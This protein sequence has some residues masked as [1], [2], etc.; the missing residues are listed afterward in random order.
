MKNTIPAPTPAQL[1]WQECEL[2]M[3]YHMDPQWQRLDESARVAPEE[4]NPERFNASE[5]LDVAEGFGA[6]QI[7]MVCKHGSGFCHWQTATTDF[8]IAR[9]P[10]KNGKGDIVAELAD[11]TH[12]RGLRFGIYLAPA[13][14]HEGAG[15][16]GVCKNP[17]DQERYVALYRQQLTELLSRYGEV[18]EV[19]FDGSLVFDVSD[20]LE[21]YAPNAVVFQGKHASI[22]WLGN[23]R[24]ISP[25]PAWNG[26][27]MEDARTG[28]ATAAQST[29]DGDVWM[30]LESDT[31]IRDHKWMW[32]E[33][34]HELLKSL[35]HLIDTYYQSVGHGSVLL[36]NCNPKLDGSIDPRDKARNDEF[37]A[38]IRRRF[39]V[40]VAEAKGAGEVLEIPLPQAQMIDHV[41]SA[42]VISEGERVRAYKVEARVEGAWQVVT[43]G[44]AIGLKKIDFFEP[45]TCDAMRIV[46]TEAVEKPL[47]KRVAVYYVGKIPTFERNQA[48][49]FNPIRAGDFSLEPGERK[50][51]TI[52]LTWA[53]HIAARYDIS[54]RSDGATPIIHDAVFR[55][56][57]T[58]ARDFLQGLS[59]PGTWQL[60][61]TA[62]EATKELELTV[63]NREGRP[64]S[65]RLEV[66]SA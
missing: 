40:P 57:G 30:P 47:W 56:D 35:D 34:G 52:P 16:G 60:N 59:V 2:A 43:E 33:D 1:A 13:D 55:V 14:R 64:V 62:Y 44:S 51:V 18:M 38:E 36:L 17:A 3:F 28:I 58:D 41:V 31:P 9:S 23:E 54:L 20:I 26:V 61:V 19:W 49:V 11:E 27:R 32:T 45:I 15:Q 21:K 10:W 66:R 12:R 22:R 50:Q 53:C 42:E 37:G 24:G 39:G 29:P 46:V 65:C 5:W 8:S 6:K 48:T 63:E 25:Y 4:F 7:V